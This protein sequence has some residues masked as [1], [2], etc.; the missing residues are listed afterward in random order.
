M[1]VLKRNDIKKLKEHFGGNDPILGKYSK[2]W[3]L[4]HDHD[5]G[6]CRG[7]ID[8]DINQF[9]GKIES[10]YKRFVRHKAPS[11]SLP[12]VLQD[13]SVYLR[14]ASLPHNKIGTVLHP[15]GVLKLCRQF[16]YKNASEQSKIL[17][18]MYK[19]TIKELSNMSKAERLKLYKAYFT[20]E[21]RIF[22]I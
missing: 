10:A 2:N 18:T 3:V 4:D 16:S 13:I 14:M 12:D 17:K 5:T 21:R 9:I 15:E 22:K 1:E 8:R 7:I 6:M 11:V 20:D 19:Y